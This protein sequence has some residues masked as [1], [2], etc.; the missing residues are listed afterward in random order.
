M[1]SFKLMSVVAALFVTLNLF[2][3]TA[4]EIAA[5][6][7]NAMGGKEVFDKVKS[8]VM[9]SEVSVMGQ[10]FP[11]VTTILID[12]GFKNV[13]TV[14]GMEIIQ[15]HTPA[16]SWMLNPMMGMTTPSP[17]DEDQR[18][19][20]PSTYEIGGP[21]YHYKERGGT[22]E[23][24]GNEDVNG[25]KTT[26]LKLKDT[27][28]VEILFYIDPATYYIVREDVKGNIQ[29]Q[30]M[31]VT[32]NYSAFKKTDIGLVMPYVRSTT[33]QGFDVTITHNKIDFNKEVDPKIFE[34]P[35]S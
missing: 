27:S 17:V 22:L 4:D 33:T 23:L 6:H 5:K 8:V 29:G 2:A 14:N 24:A 9:E 12:K 30:E 35:K 31:T 11:S 34:I 3:Q 26:K 19:M 1:K 15:V 18:K 16:A 25:V 13:T 32:S 20:S 7:F 21:L 10:S 28:G